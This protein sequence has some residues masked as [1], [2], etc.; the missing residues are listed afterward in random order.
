LVSE[1]VNNISYQLYQLRALARENDRPIK[2]TK[3]NIP[4]HSTE[5]RRLTFRFSHDFTATKLNILKH[6]SFCRSFRLKTL[7]HTVPSIGT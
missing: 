7:S 5:F 6:R 2:K 3:K 1:Q 4:N